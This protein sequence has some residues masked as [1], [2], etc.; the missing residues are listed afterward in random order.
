MNAR[1]D[2][3]CATTTP[4]FRRCSLMLISA[5]CL[6]LAG[7]GEAREAT[8]ISDQRE[9]TAGTEQPVAT[10]ASGLASKLTFKATDGNVAFSIKPKDDGA[11]LVDANEQ[12]VARFNV[13]ENKLKIKGTDDVVL[14]YVIASDG[15]Y[16]I[17]DAAQ[18]I[19][20]WKLQRQ[21]DGD[22][23]LETGKDELIYKIKVRDYGFEIEDGDENSKFKIKLKEDKTS[24]RDAADQTVFY[25]KDKVPTI[26][27]SCLGLKAIESLPLRTG[28][29]TMLIISGDH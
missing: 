11:K 17:E 8:A 21:S 14:G 23:K 12:E 29:M 27:V 7:C 24:V 5:C 15:K 13:S 4:P 22:W 16:K 19:E 26:A 1:H 9:S 18:E 25:T 28:L 2:D 10:P 6:L 3:C 20:L